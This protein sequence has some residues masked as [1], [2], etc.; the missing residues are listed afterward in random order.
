MV[1]THRAAQ[2]VP[3]WQIEVSA[4]DGWLSGYNMESLTTSGYF[5]RIDVN[6]CIEYIQDKNKFP[7]I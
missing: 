1:Q 7:K 2:R 4:L 6:W 3:G 5:Y